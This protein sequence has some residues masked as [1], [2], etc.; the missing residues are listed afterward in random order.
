MLHLFSHMAASVSILVAG[1][2]SPDGETF[3]A[4][5]ILAYKPEMKSRKLSLLLRQCEFFADRVI[6]RDPRRK[7]EVL[8]DS[9]LL[10]GI[11]W[12]L[13]WNHWKHW[14][15]TRIDVDATF[16]RTGKYRSTK[17]RMDAADLALLFR[18]GPK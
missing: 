15:R 4:D 16:V 5:R 2:L 10:P 3:F 12:D 17:G 13:T 14:L 11:H 7:I 9:F 18:R 8:L 6:C 1:R